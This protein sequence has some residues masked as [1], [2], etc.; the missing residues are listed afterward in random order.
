MN[1]FQLNYDKLLKTRFIKYL[2]NKVRS[3]LGMDLINQ[4]MGYMLLV[5]Q[6]EWNTLGIWSL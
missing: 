3:P 2:G 5:K 4:L 6:R 1:W